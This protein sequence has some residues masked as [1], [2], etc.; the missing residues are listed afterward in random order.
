M[1]GQCLKKLTRKL[2]AKPGIY[3]SKA[4][5]AKIGREKLG[6][7]KFQRKAAMGRKK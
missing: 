2:A 7:A 4:L 1:S 5:A 6:K 3:A